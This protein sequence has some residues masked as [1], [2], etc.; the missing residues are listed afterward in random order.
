MDIESKK[1]FE[2][3]LQEGINIFTG[4]GFSVLSSDKDGR[5]LPIG[6]DLKNELLKKFP[7]TP[8]TLQLPQLCTLIS[9]SKRDSLN[10]YIRSRFNVGE[11]PEVY[12]NIINVNIKNI[13]TTNVDNL[14]ECIFKGNPRKYINNTMFNGVSFQEKSAIDYYYLHGAVN[15]V[16]SN[17]IFGDLDIANAFSSDP[18][19][20]NYL[21][22]VMN[23]YP[24]LFWGYA[25]RDAGTLQVFADSL[26]NQNKKNAWIIV[27]P[28]YVDEGE[29][30]YYQ[31][32]DIKIIRSDT[33]S[34][35]DYLGSLEVSEFE[36]IKSGEYENP[37]PEHSIPSHSDIKHRS[38][39]D[40]YQGAN[41]SWSDIYSSQVIKLH[42]YSVVEE[43]INGNKNVLITGGPATGK[44]T[45]LMQVAAFHSFNGIKIFVSNMSLAKA[46][47]FSTR[48]NNTPVL[49]FVD[50]MQTSID[51][52]NYLSA[53]SNIKMVIAE[54]DYAY[55]SASRAGFLRKNI[56]IIDITQLNDTDAQGVTDHIPADL[57]SRKN[58]KLKDGDSLFEL[59]ESNCRTP[60]IKERFNN[61]LKDLKRKDKRLV[62]LFLLV[63]YL[64]NSRSVTSMDVLYSYFQNEGI[65]YKEI[66]SFISILSSCLSE[67]A[68][69]FSESTQDY[70]SIRSNLLS[71]HI[72]AISPEQEL[73]CMLTNFHNNVS[74]Y[75][76]PN[77]DSF[78]RRA[79]DARL[80]ER[81]FPDTDRGEEIY[82]VIY[83]KH[84]SPFNLQQKALYLSRRGSHDRAFIVIDEAI[85]KSGSENWSVKNSYAIIKFKANINRT[86]SLG[87][88]KALDESMV[89]LEQCYTA[90]M[91]KAFHAMS[92][93]GQSLKYW[94]KYRDS[95]AIEYLKKSKIWLGEEADKD[96]SIRN[97]RR[98]LQQVNNALR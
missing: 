71:E 80:F 10:D 24:I 18:T 7:G 46:E 62:E 37:F 47:T 11:F 4:A 88:R 83:R 89:S 35:L 40:F 77:Y 90:D 79:Y 27:H 65:G 95:I 81:A 82:D 70:F 94:A 33:E 63:C 60:A 41:P 13:F 39:N 2:R 73:A 57:K 43:Y 55:L 29:I 50:N 54:R 31:S 42:Y 49:L 5:L 72:V 21:K 12:K 84:N 15:D 74:R 19:K 44:S 9:K 32:L 14:I 75:C 87:V 17:L 98:L 28:D 20:W 64:H 25:L 30:E 69:E 91:R 36:K 22:S 85:S 53:K 34:F 38:I 76:I 6:D 61:V 68:G 93:A 23:K 16:E 52:L 8:A 59:I 45:L 3:A 58:F 92:Y 66:Y 96:N 26:D 51:A 78:K 1:T 86:D 56:E 48:I 97:V 67:Y